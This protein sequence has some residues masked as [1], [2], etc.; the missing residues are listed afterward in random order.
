MKSWDDISLQSI[1]NKNPHWM[2]EVAG[3]ALGGA[4]RDVTKVQEGNMAILQLIHQ[5]TSLEPD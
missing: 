2:F 3:R 4:V 1:R 5:L